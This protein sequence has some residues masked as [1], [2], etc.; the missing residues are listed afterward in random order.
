LKHNQGIRIDGIYVGGTY[1]V[2]EARFGN[3][4]T[5]Y[6]CI[7][8]SGCASDQRG[9]TAVSTGQTIAINNTSTSSLTGKKHNFGVFFALAGGCIAALGA[10]IVI[11]VRH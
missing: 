1:L 8:D 9:G 6:S 10:V 11:K 4:T 2:D 7:A 5:T 3:Y